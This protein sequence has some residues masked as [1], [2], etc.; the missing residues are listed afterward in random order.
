MNQYR[1]CGVDHLG[2]QVMA[3]FFRL[4]CA[5]L[6]SRPS[7]CVLSDGKMLYLG[8]FQLTRLSDV[9]GCSPATP[10]LGGVIVLGL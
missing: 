7:H 9:Y 1:M 8:L 10:P 6:K 3:S 5:M 2:C 4:V